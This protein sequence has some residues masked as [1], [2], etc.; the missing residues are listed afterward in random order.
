M[1]RWTDNSEE[2]MPW[3]WLIRTTNQSDQLQRQ[4]DECTVEQL[5]SQLIQ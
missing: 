3:A 2:D 5:H 4:T 1:R